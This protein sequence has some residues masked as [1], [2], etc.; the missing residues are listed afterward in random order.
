MLGISSRTRLIAVVVAGAVA[1]G[2]AAAFSAWQLAVLIGW[3]VAATMFVV[4]VWASVARFTPDQTRELSTREDDG[5]VATTILLLSAS[6]VSLV[7]VALALFKAS[8]ANTSDQAALTVA[9][10]VTVAL[11]WVVVHTVFTLRYARQYYT[12]PEGG[13]DFKADDEDPDYQDFAYFAFTIG[14][15]FQVSDTDV[16]GR[17]IRRTVLKHSLLSYLFGAVILAVVINVIAGIVK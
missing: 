7:G 10:V 9:A 5:R 15:T 6:V 12:R 11:S 8:K 17:K 4:W 1:G 14:M 13:I 16:Q 3:G 2:V